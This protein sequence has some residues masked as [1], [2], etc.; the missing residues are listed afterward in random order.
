[1]NVGRRKCKSATVSLVREDVE[2]PETAGE[3][4]NWRTLHFYFLQMNN[5]VKRRDVSTEN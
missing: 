2:T 1:M 4:L 5:V 3:G